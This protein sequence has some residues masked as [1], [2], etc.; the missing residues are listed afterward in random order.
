MATAALDPTFY[1][2]AADAA[3]RRSK[4]SLR[5]GVRPRGS[6]RRDAGVD[7]KPRPHV[8]Q[9]R[10]LVEVARRETSSIT[11]AGTPAAPR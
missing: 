9:G 7:V 6:A 8:Q 4:T 3:Q 2:T 10:R 11:T 5:G 1:R